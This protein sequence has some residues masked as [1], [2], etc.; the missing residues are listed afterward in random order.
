MYFVFQ[1]LVQQVVPTD[2]LLKT[3]TPNARLHGSRWEGIH[4]RGR[5]EISLLHLKMGRGM[6][7]APW[8]STI[9]RRRWPPKVKLKRSEAVAGALELVSQA[10]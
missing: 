4:C 5:Q 1:K 8:L 10:E 2:I 9:Y 6:K 7:K 3:K